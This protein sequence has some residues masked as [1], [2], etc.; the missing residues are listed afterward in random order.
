MSLINITKPP[1][2]ETMRSIVCLNCNAWFFSEQPESNTNDELIELVRK[3][4]KIHLET[5]CQR[6]AKM[7]A[8]EVLQRWIE[9]ANQGRIKDGTRELS[10]YELV[11]IGNVL[12]AVAR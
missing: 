4:A 8:N 6:G 12:R 5:R 10:N 9:D 2:S 11:L 7:N 3:H 1:S